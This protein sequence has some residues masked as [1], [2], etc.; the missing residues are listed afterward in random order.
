MRLKNYEE[1]MRLAKQYIE[2]NNLKVI[3][4]GVSKVYSQICHKKALKLSRP[5]VEFYCEA[6]NFDPKEFVSKG[7]NMNINELENIINTRLSIEE[8]PQ[9]DAIIA[10]YTLKMGE[11]NKIISN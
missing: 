4:E 11:N 1:Q 5:G 2:Y 3:N 6:N 7:L 9:Q 10:Y 8:P